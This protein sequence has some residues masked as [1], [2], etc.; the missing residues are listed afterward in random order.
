[1]SKYDPL[2]AFLRNRPQEEERIAL[3]LDEIERVLGTA[4]PRTAKIDRPWWANTRSSLHAL[5]WLDAG[6]KVDK[7]DFKAGRVTFIRTGT[8]AVESK[9]GRNRYENLQR[10]FKS[11]PP[12]QEQIALTFK[13]LAAVLGGKLPVTASHDRPWWANTKSS[14]QGSSWMAAGWKVERV[15]L[16][17]EVVTFRRKG[18]NPLKSIPRYVE[19]LLNGS[20]HYGR[21]TPNTLASWLRFCKRVG[22][23][24]E[25]TI[26][27]ERGGLNT[28]IL[29]ESECAEVDEDYAVCKR[30]LSRYKDDTNAMRKRNCHG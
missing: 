30:E 5:R 7:V 27:Y 3:S 18:V 10:F 1:M 11:I 26:L 6:W 22:W 17:A 21:P 14:P 24:F 15:Y 16:K 12:Q 29:S 23:Y 13:E 20:T 19:G 8:E 28:D 4:L 2:S 9:S 25:A